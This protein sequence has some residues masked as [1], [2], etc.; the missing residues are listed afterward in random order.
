MSSCPGSRNPR[1]AG[2]PLEQCGCNSPGIGAWLLELQAAGIGPGETGDAVVAE[3]P[4]VEVDDVADG[5]LKLE[6]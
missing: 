4:A 6:L 5:Q 1:H 2:T 3:A